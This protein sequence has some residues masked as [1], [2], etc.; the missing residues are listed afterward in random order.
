MRD[1]MEEGGGSAGGH[2][3]GEGG[4]DGTVFDGMGWDGI[5]RT[6]GF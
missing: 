4:C 3:E 6:G 5:G 1:R 2:G